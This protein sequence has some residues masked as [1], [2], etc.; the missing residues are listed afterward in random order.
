MYFFK[1]LLKDFYHLWRT[2]QSREFLRLAWKYGDKNRYEPTKVNF[3]GYQFDVPDAFSFLWQ[4]F[5]IFVEASYAFKSDKTMPVIY[6]C[7]AN[8]GTSCVFFKEQYPEA[9]IKAFEADPAIGKLL[10]TNLHRHNLTDIEIVHKAVW[11]HNNGIELVQEGADGASVV[12][13]GNKINVPSVRLA[14][15]LQ[16]EPAIDLLKMDIEGAETKVILDC[17]D[18]LQHV[19]NIFVEYHSFP[20]QPQQ[21]DEILGVLKESGFRVFV[22]NTQP[23]KSPFIFHNRENNTMDLQ[24][25]IF[26]YRD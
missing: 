13:E 19:Q 20:G 14:E 7:G 3:L 18:S 12:L 21:L 10:T 2:P 8:V 24:L 26:G 15:L 25:D 1:L 9:K 16:N 17:K 4:F 11:V 6:D 22:K 23:R 5:E